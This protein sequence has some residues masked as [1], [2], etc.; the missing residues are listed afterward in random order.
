MAKNGYG[1]LTFFDGCYYE[2]NWK[3]NKIE[4]EGT[5]ISKNDDILFKGNWNNININI[6]FTLINSKNELNLKKNILDIFYK[7]SNDKFE[8]KDDEFI[9]LSHYEKRIK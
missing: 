7:N 9:F 5:F 4:G 8:T 3:N 2:G 6:I 1:I